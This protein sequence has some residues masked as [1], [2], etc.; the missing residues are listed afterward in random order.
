MAYGSWVSK[1]VTLYNGENYKIT[2]TWSYRQ[3][4]IENKTQIKTEKIK[5]SSVKSGY[6]FKTTMA[7]V[8]FVSTG[9]SYS[10]LKNQ[11]LN[12]ASLGSDEINTV[13]STGT[14]S[15]DSNGN[16]PSGR[17][18]HWY[19]D[20]GLTVIGYPSYTVSEWQHTDISGIP[21]IDR[22]TPTAKIESTTKSYT[23]I[24]IN[25]STTYAGTLYA[26]LGTS[27]SWKT[28]KS[29]IGSGG[30][31]AS[32]TF[33][34]LTP[35]KSYT[36]QVYAHR[37]YNNTNSTTVSKTVSTKA[38]PAPDVPQITASSITKNSVKIKM[39]S[40]GTVYDST[41]TLDG[42][43]GNLSLNIYDNA[44]FDGA[45]QYLHPTIAQLRAGY[46]I[47][48]LSA[49]KKYAI[50]VYSTAPITA[51]NNYSQVIFTTK[52]DSVIY[53]KTDSG[54]KQGIPYI[55]TDSGWKQGIPYVKTGSGW[56]QGI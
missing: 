30:G 36:I 38:V 52:S 1:T 2:G 27:G 47:S 32:Y 23:K 43:A 8:G 40:G 26:R 48:G 11:S 41:T 20:P 22:A 18:I 28:I 50:R 17:A 56:K 10:T 34:G 15:H 42:K 39:A 54:W 55:K 37:T 29:G 51:K 14:V 35:N 7:E 24:T 25:A 13:D 6:A 12:I 4:P 33:T 9:A 45:E 3:D 46:T 44:I 49:G 16:F 19:L 31:N 5:I 21:K 53:I